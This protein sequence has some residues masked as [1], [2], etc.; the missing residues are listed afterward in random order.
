[1]SDIHKLTL[2][3]MRERLRT[4]VFKSLHDVSEFLGRV[5]LHAT[6]RQNHESQPIPKNESAS[7]KVKYWNDSIRQL[8][9]VE[10]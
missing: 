2:V 6:I 5:L 7:M 9:P 1:M 10:S 4:S 3:E 8:S